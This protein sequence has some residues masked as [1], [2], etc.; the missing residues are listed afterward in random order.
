MDVWNYFEPN[1]ARDDWIA[2]DETDVTMIL[3]PRGL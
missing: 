2:W 3:R 1:E